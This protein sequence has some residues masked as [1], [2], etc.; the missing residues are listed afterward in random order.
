MKIKL[1]GCIKITSRACNENS[2]GLYNSI[3]K[4]IRLKNLKKV[5]DMMSQKNDAE[6]MVKKNGAGAGNYSK[7]KPFGALPYEL[8][9]F[10]SC[11]MP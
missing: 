10:L 5:V 1:S 9:R 2:Q 4:S 6:R 3:A 7:Y 8:Q 11:S